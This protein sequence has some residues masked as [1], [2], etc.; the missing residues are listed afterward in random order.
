MDT[1]VL[2][3]ADLANGIVRRSM[4]ELAKATVV[5]VKLLVF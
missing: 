3:D 4:N 5:L 1:L 2:M